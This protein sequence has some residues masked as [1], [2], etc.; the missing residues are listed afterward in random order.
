MIRPERGGACLR[1]VWPEATRDGIVGNCAEAGVLGPV[2]GVFGSLQAFEA[3]KLLL[4][5]PGQLTDEVLVLDLL[6]FS[7]SRVRTRR[8]K[9]CP[10][11]ARNP[12]AEPADADL[13]V[14]FQTLD[15][16]HR[17]GFEI[18]DIREPHELQQTPIP[19]ARYRHVPLAQMLHGSPAFAPERPCVLV[20]AS[21]RRSLAAA[22]ELRSRGVR[23]IYSLRGGIAGL[24]STA[25]VAP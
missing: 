16:A 15:L 1:C 10:D 8:A 17:A 4:D 20:C 6:T 9:S 7:T 24:Q 13:E 22:R 5:L 2:P 21:G 23:E 19:V 11:H 12:A 25:A 3:L 14:T 18:V